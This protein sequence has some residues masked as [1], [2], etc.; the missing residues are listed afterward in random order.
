MSE[1]RKLLGLTA[2][3]VLIFS[4]LACASGG[5]GSDENSGASSS[6]D[7][8]SADGNQGDSGSS[9]EARS[10][11]CGTKDLDNATLAELST[12]F[13]AFQSS[14]RHLQSAREDF[15]AI[16]VIFHVINKGDAYEDGNLSDAMIQ[17]QVDVL[18]QVFSGQRGGIVTPFRFTLAGIDRVNNPDWFLM[19]PGS[20]AEVDAKTALRKGGADTLNIFTVNTEGG[21]LGFSTFP[22]LYLALPQ[23]DGVVINFMTLPGGTFNHYSTGYVAVHEVGHWLGLLHTF[24][25]GCDQ[26]FGDLVA[27][28]PAEMQPEK[29]EF[30]P[31]S[32]DSCPDIEGSDPIH[33]HMTYTADECRNDFTPGQLDLMQFNFQAFRQLAF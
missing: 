30:C 21:V 14:R 26:F 8:P 28:T 31:A 12:L 18:N 22:I 24:Q 15:P 4:A 13:T 16:P 29:G 11:N 20:Q 23:F 9:T 1:L 25:G 5:G 7:F 17:S 27:D 2:G 19:A 33:N 6:D 3:F 32:R 10:L